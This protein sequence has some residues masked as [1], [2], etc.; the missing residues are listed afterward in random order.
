L[1]LSLHF[2]LWCNTFPLSFYLLITAFVEF[3]YFIDRRDRNR[4]TKLSRLLK[5]HVKTCGLVILFGHAPLRCHIDASN[6]LNSFIVDYFLAWFYLCCRLTIQ[7][8][9][10]AWRRLSTKCILAGT[11]AFLR[12]RRSLKKLF[13]PVS[14][15]PSCLIAE[16][17]RSRCFL[18]WWQYLLSS[19]RLRIDSIRQITRLVHIIAQGCETCFLQAQLAI[20][21][22]NLVETSLSDIII[23]LL[24]IEHC[25]RAIS[26]LEKLFIGASAQLGSTWFLGG[27]LM[28]VYC[29]ITTLRVSRSQQTPVIDDLIVQ[30]FGVWARCWW[31]LSLLGLVWVLSAIFFRT[32]WIVIFDFFSGVLTGQWEFRCSLLL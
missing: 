22:L 11:A 16:H 28:G 10:S 32:S 26:I 31:L 9:I 8:A 30:L 15:I 7:F 27:A 21:L 6:L 25:D 2:F 24:D 23:C 14:R 13:L 29:L 20:N 17:D 19:C 18:V 5:R 3:R 1:G 12:C 4:A